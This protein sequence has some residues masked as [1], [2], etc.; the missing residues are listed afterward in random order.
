M[1]RFLSIRSFKYF[2]AV[3]SKSKV[4][5][6]SVGGMNPSAIHKRINFQESILCPVGNAASKGIISYLFPLNR[7]AVFVQDTCNHYNCKRILRI[8]IYLSLEEQLSFVWITLELPKARIVILSNLRHSSF[9]GIY[10]LRSIAGLRIVSDLIQIPHHRT[11]GF[12][13]S[14]ID[15]VLVDGVLGF[16]DHAPDLVHH[17]PQDIVVVAA[18]VLRCLL[19]YGLE[20]VEVAH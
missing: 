3:R 17:V 2:S 6:P 12:V 18:F 1:R 9:N 5:P 8:V 11:F 19:Q 10:L 16:V 4:Y 20:R 15:E 7:S 14:G 13:L